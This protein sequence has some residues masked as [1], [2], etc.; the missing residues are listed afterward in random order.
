MAQN[1]EILRNTEAGKDIY[2]VGSGKSIDFVPDSFWEGKVVVG[3][4][5]VPNRV[6]CQ[7]LVCHHYAILQPF[8]DSGKVKVITSEVEACILHSTLDN[9]VAPTNT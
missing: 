4:N 6:P 2:V 8:I 5:S 3:V 1:I 9:W 7:Y